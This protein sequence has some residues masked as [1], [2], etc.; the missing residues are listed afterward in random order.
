MSAADFA[1]TAALPVIPAGEAEPSNRRVIVAWQI[2][3]KIVDV[4]TDK[5]HQTESLI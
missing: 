3:Y 1:K 2:V 4:P 5:D